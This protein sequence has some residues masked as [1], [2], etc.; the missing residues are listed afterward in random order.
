MKNLNAF[1]IS[2]VSGG[3]DEIKKYCDYQKTKDANV[4]VGRLDYSKKA[5]ADTQASIQRAIIADLMGGQAKKEL[6]QEVKSGANA[7]D[8]YSFACYTFTKEQDL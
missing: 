8:A 6:I 2:A 5:D 1:E 7:T 3:A 4:V